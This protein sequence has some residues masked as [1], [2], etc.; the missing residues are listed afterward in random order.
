MI[1]IIAD[2]VM[3]RATYLHGYSSCN[4]PARKIAIEHTCLSKR[5]L[6]VIKYKTHVSIEQK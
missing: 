1:D 6:T 5:A 3:C 4:I 2:I